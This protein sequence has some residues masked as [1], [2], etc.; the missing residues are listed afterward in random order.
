MKKL[1]LSFLAVSL[2]FSVNAQKQRIQA[3]QSARN[4]AVEKQAAID[5][6]TNLQ[7]T[8]NPYVSRAIP[9]MEAEIGGTVYDLQS[10]GSSPSNR[11]ELFS[12]GTLGATWNRGTGPAAYTDRGTGYNYFNGAA[13][14]PAPTN[15]IETARSGWPAYT[16]CGATGEAFVSHISGTTPLNFY[17]RD[18]KG[19]GEW[20]SST[21]AAPAGASGLLW[22]R[23]TS[24]GPNNEILH[25]I[26]LTA[27]VANGG[28]V[29][30][31]QDGAVVY[32]RSTDA[33][34]TWSTPV[35]LPEMTSDY[36]V[37]FGGDSYSL[38]SVGDNVV[39]LIT[40]NWTDLFTMTSTD[41]GENWERTVIWEHPIPLWNNTPSIDTIYCPDGAGQAIFDHS[42]KLHVTFGVNRGLFEEGGTAPSWFPFVDG[43]AYWNEDMP[44]WTGGDQAN[45]LNPDNLYASGN[46]IGYMVDLNGNGTLDWIGTAIENIGLYYVSPTSMPQIVI[47]QYNGIYVVYTSVT[48]TFDNGAQ[49]YRHLWLTYS[50]DGGT[51]WGDQIHLSEDIIH[52]LDECVFPSVATEEGNFENYVH[53][54][55]QADAEPGLAIRGDEDAPG[56]NIIYYLQIEKPT[57]GAGNMPIN[58]KEIQVSA[59]YPN[60]FTNITSLD[61]T[62]SQKAN[63]SIEVYSVTGQRVMEQTYGQ[64]PAGMFKLDINASDLESGLYIVK[65]K[66]GDQSSTARINVL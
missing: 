49:Q 9:Q 29:Y 61:V 48:E 39:I 42:G 32:I 1:L 64:Y 36:Y 14:G 15:R 27:P 18:V 41:N 53:V 56:E 34:A 19:T 28:T 7:T 51:T 52:F 21:I 33:G 11:L 46:L 63:V 62:L 4:I 24:S 30:N 17:K 25:V 3:P 45:V 5:E 31:G 10:N 38:N 47:D 37:A 65:V 2:V 6:T 55:Y 16:K 54:I 22:P 50:L 35:V 43:L 40:D 66:A 8:V 58:T 59:A 60:P 20:T 57:I 44:T 12:D 13:W 23:M 26:A